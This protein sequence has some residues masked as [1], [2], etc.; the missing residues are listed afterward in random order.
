MTRLANGRWVPGR[1]HDR[2]Y[3]LNL[4]DANYNRRF[5]LNKDK[6]ANVLDILNMPPYLLTECT[7]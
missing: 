7:E 3:D 4:G 2:Q 6:S 1:R 5:D